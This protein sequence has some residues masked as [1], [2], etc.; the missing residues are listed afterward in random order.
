MRLMELAELV[1]WSP[2]YGQ[3]AARIKSGHQ[4]TNKSVALFIRSPLKKDLLAL[5]TMA[6]TPQL[7]LRYEVNASASVVVMVGGSER[8]LFVFGVVPRSAP[9]A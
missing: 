4:I 3:D 1:R 2:A 5:P 9:R 7:S 8:T 6:P